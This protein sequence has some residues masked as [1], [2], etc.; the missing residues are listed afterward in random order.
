MQRAGKNQDLDPVLV[1]AGGWD[2]RVT[3]NVEHEM[4]L[5]QLAIRL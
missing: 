3:E 2:A 4:E 5:R 1:I